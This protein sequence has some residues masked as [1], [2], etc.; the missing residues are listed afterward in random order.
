VA[1]IDT[2]FHLDKY[3][4]HRDLYKEINS[5]KQYTLCVTNSPG[6]YLSCQSTYAET[7]CVKFALG[8]HPLEISDPKRCIYEFDYCFSIAKYLGEVGLDY[9]KDAPPR[10]KQ[11]VVFSHILQKQA[12]ANKLISIH[13][14]G[15]EEDALK[16]LSEYTGQKRII[17]WFTGDAEN[18]AEFVNLGCY[19]SLNASM[20]RSVDRCEILKSIP[21]ERI[22]VESDGPYTKVGGRK[23]TPALLKETYM[24]IGSAIGVQNLEEL[25]YHNFAQLLL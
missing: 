17:H 20:V 10:E 3:R 2:H 11:L 7:K 4:E 1:L 13:I 16:I 19:F 5:L 21:L 14:R 22:L 25:A 15:A 12:A 8:M 6:I 18:L 23:Y 9:S 24:V